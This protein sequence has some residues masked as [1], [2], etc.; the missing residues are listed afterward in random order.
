MIASRQRIKDQNLAE[1]SFSHALQ[2]HKNYSEHGKLPSCSNMC[3]DAL[4]TFA[5]NHIHER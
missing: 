4:S 5:E 3:D 2:R 1:L